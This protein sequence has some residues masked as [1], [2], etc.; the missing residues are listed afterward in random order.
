MQIRRITY[1][2]LRVTGKFEND[3]AEVEVEINPEDNIWDAA[4]LAKQRCEEILMLPDLKE[5]AEAELKS[6]F[7]RTPQY[8]KALQ[9]YIDQS[10]CKVSP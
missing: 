4:M 3:R 9:S 7:V 8:K 1:A 2:M 10:A 6:A 5:K